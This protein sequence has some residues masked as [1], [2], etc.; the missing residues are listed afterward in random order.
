VRKR[1]TELT[2]S[3]G[4]LAFLH[5]IDVSAAMR[6]SNAPLTAAGNENSEQGEP[7]VG[8]DTAPQPEIG[9]QEKG[10]TVSLY[11][12]RNKKRKDNNT[13]TLQKKKRKL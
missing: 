10:I 1:F 12:N 6:R 7:Y 8:S 13:P 2:G 5:R 9:D 4:S 11:N 3:D